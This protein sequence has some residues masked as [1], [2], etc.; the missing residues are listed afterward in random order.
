MGQ[1]KDAEYGRNK[2]HLDVKIKINCG[3]QSR[4]PTAPNGQNIFP[5][6]PK[7]WET[8]IARDTLRIDRGNSR[9]ER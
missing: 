8:L 2:I 1:Q 5:I 4:P 3:G 6:F 7:E 9:N